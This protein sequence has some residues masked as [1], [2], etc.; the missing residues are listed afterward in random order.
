MHKR[1][2]VAGVGAFVAVAVLA[3]IVTS[4]APQ[5]RAG[6]PD[7]VVTRSDPGKAKLDEAL[8]EKVDSGSTAEVAVFVTVSGDASRVRALL[9][10][11]AT[12]KRSGNALVVGRIGTQAVPKVAGLKNVVSVGLVQL[13]QTGR[14]LGDPDPQVGRR[15]SLQART[16]ALREV[17]SGEVP[18]SKAPKPKGSNFEQLRKLGVLD[19]KTHNFKDAW[20]AGYAGEG[21][22][23]GVLD[24]G[25]DFGHPDLLNTWRVWSGATDSATVDAGWNGWPKAYD[26]FGTLQWLAAPSQVADG[27]SWYTPTSA[28][29]C[30]ALRGDC[31]VQFGTRTGPS[32][33][34]NAP[35]GTATHTYRF[36]RRWSTSGTVRLGSHPD[37]YLLDLYGERPAFLVVDSRQ[38]GVYDTVYV[39]LDHDNDFGDEKPVSKSSPS[40]YRDINGDGY[41]DLSGGLLYFISDGQTRIPGGLTEFLGPDT[42]APAPGALLAWSGDFDP[43]IEGHGT[44]TASNVVGQGVING[45]RRGSPTCRRTGASPAR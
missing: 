9:D 31:Q 12:A 40:S 26:P 1:I 38:A 27:L 41:T 34:F 13:K 23:V 20:D 16:Q 44:L 7:R 8:R 24:G 6:E 37:D 2:R 33:N 19:A 35:S 5:Q 28:A 11:D 45:R 29:T 30:T 21:V 17:K 36:P 39:D 14:P 43:G 18:Y 22:T 10:R 42:P 25:T 4:A 15:P 32:R 3:T